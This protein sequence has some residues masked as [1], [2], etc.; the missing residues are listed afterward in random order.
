MPTLSRRRCPTA[1]LTVAALLG[2]VVAPGLAGAQ[3][4]F[5]LT[6]DGWSETPAADPASPEGQ[7]RAARRAF[8]SGR[9]DEALELAEAWTEAFPNHPSQPAARLL[10]GDAKAAQGD[11]YLSLF[12]Y[13]YVIRA[14]PGSAEF[15]VA[16]EREYEIAYLYL[17]G[18]KR[19][20]WGFRVL[21]AQGEAEEILIR[22]QER[23]P[24]TPLAERAMLRLGDHYFAEGD[25]FLASEAYDLFVE[26][27]PDSADRQ[28][29]TL[30]L[31]HAELAR[32][33][34]TRFDPTGLLEARQRLELFEQEFPAA[35]EQINSRALIRRIESTLARK[36]LVTAQWFQTRGETV[37]AAYLFNRIAED[38]PGTEA[39]LLAVQE[40][41]SIG[42]IPGV[43]TVVHPDPR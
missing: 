13:E 5:E 24:S 2:P 7:L 28:Y 37:S 36:Q 17:T 10:M 27:Y 40:L 43:Q 16:L 12:D 38:Y 42:P 14:Y 39:S 29:A 25:M 22:I 32:F 35:A 6:E 19:K 23:V 4:R 31:I 8:A 11:Y 18:T 26:L 33:R 1:V 15:N 3:D 21:P 30:R 9:Y 34:D 20:F 41:E